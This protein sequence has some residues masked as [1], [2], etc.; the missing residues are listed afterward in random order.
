M[1][2]MDPFEGFRQGW[3]ALLLITT[4]FAGVTAS[5]SSAEGGLCGRSHSQI[6]SQFEDPSHRIAFKNHGG[7]FNGGVCWWHSRLQRSSIYLAQYSPEQPKPTLQEAR[8]LIDHLIR[9]DSVVSIPGYR[10][11]REFSLDFRP[12]IQESL[13]EW[14]IRDGFL[15]QQWTR[16]LYG[17]SRLSAKGLKARMKKIFSRFKRSKPGLWVM[18]QHPGITS[19]AL[20]VI[21]MTPTANGFRL[22]AIDSNLPQGI[23]E[24]EYQ[25]GH[26]SLQL[27]GDPFI[28]YAGFESDER[29][30]TRVLNRHCSGERTPPLES[31]VTVDAVQVFE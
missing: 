24:I 21:G 14:Q 17:R 16:G 18:A 13:N 4:C 11:F 1:E 25:S 15:Y 12:L 29:K 19:H 20:L 22:R 27:A 6:L 23:R 8:D 30:I 31:D 9:M 7:L 10:N 2:S 3:R 5:A 26:H 28:P